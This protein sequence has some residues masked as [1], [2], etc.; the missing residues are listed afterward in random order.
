MRRGV[1]QRES[2]GEPRSEL[3][4][5]R[6]E[7]TDGAA[8]YG[9]EV[10]VG[11]RTS[12]VAMKGSDRLIA[13]RDVGDVVMGDRETAWTNVGLRNQKKKKNTIQKGLRRRRSD[14]HLVSLCPPSVRVNT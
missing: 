11:A 14:T 1:R 10:G 7:K 6:A 4:R 8:P 13:S 2:K 9:S 12:E 5:T 3:E